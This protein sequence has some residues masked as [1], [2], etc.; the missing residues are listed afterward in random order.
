MC[1]PLKLHPGSAGGTSPVAQGFVLPAMRRPTPETGV[2]QSWREVV[3]NRRFFAYTLAGA[4]HFALFNQLYLAIPLEAQRV[5]GHPS[6]VTAVFVVSTTV[7]L[8][9][10]VRPV[11]AC[12]RRWSAAT[13]MA[14]GLSLLAA[15]F[16][17]TAVAAPLTPTA[18]V[19]LGPAAALSAALPVLAGTVLFS[20]GVSIT[21]PFMLELVPVVGSERLSGTCYGFFYLVSSLLAAVVSSVTGVLLDL[22]GVRWLPF[23]F[24]FAAGATGSV[25]MAV[26]RRSIH[27]PGRSAA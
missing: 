2:W 17:P 22:D 26:M 12:R 15:G 25:G 24:L 14:I 27:L 9:G 18:S 7:G 6:A 3:T 23:F 4:A 19:A 16:L 21:S 20:A 13:S 1:R 8:A 11:A 5:T 10:G